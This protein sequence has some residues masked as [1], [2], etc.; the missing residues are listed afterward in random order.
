MP[1]PKMKAIIA[2]AANSRLAKMRISSSARGVCSSHR[3]KPTA[4][5]A[6]TSEAQDD[7]V[8]APA[9]A[10]AVGDAGHQ[11]EQP[12]AQQREA[13]PVER[14]DLPRHAAASA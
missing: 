9:L 13:Q 3:M 7:G 10:L 12:G 2:A 1:A 5:A 4:A 6:P 8:G 14:R 11:A